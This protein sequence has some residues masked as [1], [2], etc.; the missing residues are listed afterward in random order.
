M[1]PARPEPCRGPRAPAIRSTCPGD[2]NTTLMC[3]IPPPFGSFS[4]KQPPGRASIERF[5]ELCEYV[6]SGF[7]HEPICPTNASYTFAAG[8]LIFTS[9][10]TTNPVALTC[11]AEC[12]D[13]DRSITKAVAT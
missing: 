5:F 12:A 10:F 8:A 2:T 9:S 7:H 6:C 3:S 4:Q 1:L 11:G 13:A